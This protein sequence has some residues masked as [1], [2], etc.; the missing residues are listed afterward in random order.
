MTCQRHWIPSVCRLPRPP[1]VQKH[2][3]KQFPRHCSSRLLDGQQECSC[4]QSSNHHS[5]SLKCWTATTITDFY[6]KYKDIYYY[7][8]SN[9]GYRNLNTG[10]VLPVA[11][12]HLTPASSLCTQLWTPS[13]FAGQSMSLDSVP[14]HRTLSNQ[15]W[16]APLVKPLVRATAPIK[17]SVHYTIRC[18]NNLP[19][20]ANPSCVQTTLASA[21]PQKSSHTVPQALLLQISTRPWFEVL[22][23]CNR[24]SPCLQTI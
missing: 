11:L 13:A 4:Q 6:M 1:E 8:S 12:W 22:P 18:Q 15:I 14:A 17:Y 20:V 2:H 7:F 3:H 10:Y 21:A 5:C 24:R 16:P 19:V 9:P 23:P